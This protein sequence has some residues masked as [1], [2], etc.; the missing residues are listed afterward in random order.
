MLTNKKIFFLFLCS[1]LYATDNCDYIFHHGHH[2]FG[3][4]MIHQNL[5]IT[6]G[7]DIASELTPLSDDFFRENFLTEGVSISMAIRNRYIKKLTKKFERDQHYFDQVGRGFIFNLEQQLRDMGYEGLSS[8]EEALLSNLKDDV[9]VA[10]RQSH[11]ETNSQER[12][13]PHHQRSSPSE[14]EVDQFALSQMSQI[15]EEMPSAHLERLRRRIRHYSPSGASY[16]TIMGDTHY[17]TLYEPLTGEAKAWMEGAVIPRKTKKDPLELEKVQASLKK[18]KN[19][20]IDKKIVNLLIPYHKS[21][22]EVKKKTLKIINK[23]DRKQKE[24]IIAEGIIDKRKP[25][26]TGISSKELRENWDIY[27]ITVKHLLKD[28][29]RSHYLIEKSTSR[30]QEMLVFLKNSPEFLPDL[31]DPKFFDLFMIRAIDSSAYTADFVNNLSKADLDVFDQ[32]AF[33]ELFSFYQIKFHSKNVNDIKMKLSQ[34]IKTQDHAIFAYDNLDILVE[35]DLHN[36]IEVLNYLLK[37]VS[38]YKNARRAHAPGF[39][40]GF[41]FEKESPKATYLNYFKDP[42]VPTEEWLQKSPEYL[43]SVIGNYQMTFPTELKPKFIGRIKFELGNVSEITHKLYEID[44]KRVLKQLEEIIK[45]YQEAK[46]IHFHTSTV[47]KK[48]Y[49][50]Q[51]QFFVWH[52][53]IN[54]YFYFHRLELGGIE[55][56]LVQMLDYNP[57][58]SFHDSAG[59]SGKKFFYLGYRPNMHSSAK[60]LPKD[61]ILVDLELRDTNNS[62]KGYKEDVELVSQ[63]LLARNWE[64]FNMDRVQE[65]FFIKPEKKENFLNTVESLQDLESEN[66]DLEIFSKIEETDNLFYLPLI[67]FEE[68]KYFNFKTGQLQMASPK[69]KK[70]IQEARDYYIRELK[71]N[72]NDYLLKAQENDELKEY[73]Q[74]TIKAALKDLV[75]EWGAMAKISELY[76]NLL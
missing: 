55:T 16:A 43:E 50:Y 42:D 28:P 7:N 72:F 12:T 6:T 68:K 75:R 36:R 3:A 27:Q 32:E 61:H 49:E 37:N 30:I 39:I 52:K 10:S 4:R 23:I 69:Q 26:F 1:S 38:Y 44:H 9:L 34:W 47:F 71:N 65:V 13:T 62:L 35:K 11:T 63:S 18:L 14:E 67:R 46:A 19:K 58:K 56:S 5:H 2:G 70:R 29:S 53:L 22:S 45:D 60:Q 48:S 73:D 40:Q 24:K 25:V 51:K 21:F 59:Y 17:A 54:D 31:E 74:D 8:Q 64:K 15:R 76:G 66:F 20:E 41:S 57:V 33:N